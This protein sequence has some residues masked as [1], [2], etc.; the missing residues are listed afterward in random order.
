MAYVIRHE[1]LHLTG[2][3]LTT[4]P[5]VGCMEK[6]VRKMN[7]NIMIRLGMFQLNP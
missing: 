2:K 1:E 3:D 7:G 5:R 6:I 4:V